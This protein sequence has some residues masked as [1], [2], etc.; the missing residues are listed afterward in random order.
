MGG[1]LKKLFGGKKEDGEKIDDIIEDTVIGII[2]HGGFELSYEIKVAEDDSSVEVELFG[3]DDEYLK[4]KDGQLLDAIQLLLTRVVQH[5]IQDSKVAIMVDSD[6]FRQQANQ[7]LIKL[8]E[9]LKGIA[10]KKEKS[11][12][13]RALPP[14]DRKVIHQYLSED[15]RIKS[16][17]VG[18]GLYK[19]I[20]IYPANAAKKSDAEA[21]QTSS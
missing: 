18:D 12:Y 8:A 1:I 20:K 14:K 15:S 13:F 10:L 6:G 2:E 16:H 4:E 3:E 17:S 9:K 21:A 7:A 11:V 19:K 5:Q